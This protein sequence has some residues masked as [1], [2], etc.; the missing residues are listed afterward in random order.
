MVFLKTIFCLKDVL[1]LS[2]KQSEY[3]NTR[4]GGMNDRDQAMNDTTFFLEKSDKK[5]I[6]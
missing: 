4:G 1:F 3:N 2:F 5:Y 6:V